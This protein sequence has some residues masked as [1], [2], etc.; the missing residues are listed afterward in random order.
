MNDPKILRDDPEI[1]RKM[2]HDR[3]SKVDARALLAADAARRA[4]QTKADELRTK[5]NAGAEQFGRM[6]KAGTADSPEG[7]ALMADMKALDQSLSAMEKDQQAVEAAFLDV[8]LRVPNVPHDSVP[9]G[10]TDAEDI[11]LRTW[12]TPRAVPQPARAHWDI[13]NALGLLDPERATKIAGARFNMFTGIGARV[14]RAL[15]QFMLDLHTT[16]HG[17]TEIAPPFLISAESLQG[18]GPLPLLEDDM[19][20]TQDEDRLYL[21]PTAEVSLTAMHRDEIL[22]GSRLPLKYVAYTPSFRREAG[23]YGRDLKGLIR[24]HQFDKVEMYQLTRPD[25]A[26]AAHE[27]MTRNA[28]AVLQA[29][30]L[31]YRVVLLSTGAAAFQSHKTHDLEVW[32]PSRNGW[33]EISSVS[34]CGD[35]QARRSQIRFR[36]EKGGK[37]ELVHT[38]N[39]SGLAVGRTFAA[40]LENFVNADG[41]VTIPDALRPYLG[42]MEKIAKAV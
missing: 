19:Y 10:A 29:L 15:I 33:M 24:V 9:V 37:A 34:T 17:Y 21:I 27:E 1:L 31:P 18:A 2:L 39:G 23:S 40:L 36:R 20:R 41:S 35:F 26:P 28:E 7:A 25:L 12:G 4:L 13:G 14:E 5:K 3:N 22:D 42:G 30:E 32:A 6:K 11:E 38:L 16:R 8:W